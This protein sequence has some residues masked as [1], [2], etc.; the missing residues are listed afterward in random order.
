VQPAKT[1]TKERL[2]WICQALFGAMWRRQRQGS[3][4]ANNLTWVQQTP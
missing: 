3:T 1:N 4:G 2:A